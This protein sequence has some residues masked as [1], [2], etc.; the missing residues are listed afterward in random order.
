M[1]VEREAL[2]KAYHKKFCI[3]AECEG[4]PDEADYHLADVANEILEDIPAEAVSL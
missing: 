2:A 1:Q 3:S 4:E